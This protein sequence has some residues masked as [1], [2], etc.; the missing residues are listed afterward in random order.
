MLPAKGGQL[1]ATGLY[2]LVVTHG[3]SPMVNLLLYD[4][5]GSPTPT[6]PQKHR[7]PQRHREVHQACL[8]VSVAF[9]LWPLWC[10][11]EIRTLPIT[12]PRQRSANQSPQ[13][14]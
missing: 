2:L 6:T 10:R 5:F 9:V 1:L 12:P 4:E 7:S 8:C 11:L 14:R 3:M 13:R